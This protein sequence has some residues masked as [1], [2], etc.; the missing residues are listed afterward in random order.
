MDREFF[1]HCVEDR[2]GPGER[3]RVRR[4]RLTPDI[5]AAQLHHHHGNVARA[6]DAQGSEKA[7][8]VGD[9][10]DA[11]DDDSRLRR[12]GEIGE[13][14]GELDVAWLPVVAHRSR[15]SPRS[16]ISA[17]Q[18]DPNAPLWLI[19]LIAPMRSGSASTRLVKLATRP[20]AQV[21]N[22]HAVGTDQADAS[23]TRT[24]CQAILQ[25]DAVAALLAEARA[26]DDRGLHAL[27]RAL[28]ERFGT[29][30][31]RKRDYREVD[32]CANGRER[33]IARQ[34]LHFR[35]RG[36]DRIELPAIVEQQRSGNRAARRS[37][38]DRR[39]RR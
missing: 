26:Q 29:S 2:V 13:A 31:G 38:S 9:A 30:C 23:L 3:R 37:A 17:R 28:A 10:F 7:P 19:T 34:P 21:E 39:R 20:R 8:A 11:A 15:P 6:G 33:W 16:R 32:G 22:A 27:S 24:R 14:I 5:G 35:T 12:L 18:C 25:R 1:E 4:R 36:I